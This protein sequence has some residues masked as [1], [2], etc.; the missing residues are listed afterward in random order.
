[1]AAPE[2]NLKPAREAAAPCSP[3]HLHPAAEPAGSPAASASASASAASSPGSWQ[4]AAGR[5]HPW[6]SCHPKVPRT[7]RR[8]PLAVVVEQPVGHRPRVEG[9]QNHPVPCPSRRVWGAQRR[10]LV[11]SPGIPS[12]KASAPWNL[13]TGVVTES[14]FVIAFCFFFVVCKTVYDGKSFCFDSSV[15]SGFDCGGCES[16]ISTDHNNGCLSCHNR[17]LCHSRCLLCRSHNRHPCYSLHLHHRHPCH[18]RHPL[19]H[20]ASQSE[21]SCRRCQHLACF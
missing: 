13:E 21:C 18:R 19:H 3:Y 14:G 6:R 12:R 11:C 9:H 7:A 17:H 5:R 4:Q 10:A 16:E 20:W 15:D 2:S 8:L 1:M